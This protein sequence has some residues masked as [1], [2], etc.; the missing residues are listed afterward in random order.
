[1][2]NK[3]STMKHNDENH[4]SSKS[5]GFYGKLR[6]P[7]RIILVRHGES[8]GN[9]DEQYYENTPDWKIPVIVHT[10]LLLNHLK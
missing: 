2:G 4:I 3:K 10:V 7:K 6:L 1:M 5:Q 9:V 8:L